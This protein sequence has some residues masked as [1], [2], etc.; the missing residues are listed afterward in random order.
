MA[1]LLPALVAALQDKAGH[2][3]P[4]AQSYVNLFGSMS[5][6]PHGDMHCSPQRSGAR[7]GLIELPTWPA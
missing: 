1:G 4:F 3:E 7:P 2:C 6:G 5:R